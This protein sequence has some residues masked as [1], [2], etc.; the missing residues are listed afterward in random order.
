MEP[1]TASEHRTRPVATSPSATKARTTPRGEPAL[2]HPWQSCGLRIDD[3]A[4]PV[5]R[6]RA[7]CQPRQ[8]AL[9]LAPAVGSGLIKGG[10]SATGNDLPGT[11]HAKVARPGRI[12]IVGDVHGCLDEFQVR[13]HRLLSHAQRALGSALSEAR[14]VLGHQVQVS[15]V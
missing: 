9:R 5:G 7:R 14:V 13:W 8:I 12:I 11:V 15:H 2:D 6:S 1:R 3:P 4:S 10:H